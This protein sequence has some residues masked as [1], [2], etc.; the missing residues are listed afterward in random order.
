MP[1]II[2]NYNIH[3]D[4]ITQRQ[5]ESQSTMTSLDNRK[6]YQAAMMSQLNKKNSFHVFCKILKSRLY[7]YT[8]HNKVKAD[9]SLNHSIEAPAVECI[10]TSLS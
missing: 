1:T 2:Y 6:L 3:Y 5:K 9:S 10:C 4:E 7:C 8:T